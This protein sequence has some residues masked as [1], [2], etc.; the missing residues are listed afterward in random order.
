MIT[1]M[2]ERSALSRDR[3]LMRETAGFPTKE[4]RPAHGEPPL[5]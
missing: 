3:I 5:F 2:N 4:E 1:L